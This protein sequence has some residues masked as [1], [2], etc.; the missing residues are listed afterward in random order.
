MPNLLPLPELLDKILKSGKITLSQSQR[1]G[2]ISSLIYKGVSRSQTACNRQVNLPFVDR[3]KKR[4]LSKKDELKHHFGDQNQEKRT[5][6][7]DINFV[8][9]IIAD[10]P[11]S[12]API[13]FDQATKDRIIAIALG[14]PSQYGIPIER[15]S[16]EILAAYLIEQG[17]V[18]HICSSSVSNFLKSARGK[19]PS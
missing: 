12:G 18:D 11:R 16:Q 2:V 7:K 4:W 8:L 17:I 5:L 14:K 19:T 9:A 1:L 10:A 6:S 13:K 15:W 3:W